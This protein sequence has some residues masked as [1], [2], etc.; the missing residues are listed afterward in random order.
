[1]FDFLLNFSLASCECSADDDDEDDFFSDPPPKKTRQT[2]VAQPSSA[3]KK[4]PPVS[5]PGP[6]LVT[7]DIIHPQ[8]KVYA[9]FIMAILIGDNNATFMFSQVTLQW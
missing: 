6:K 1:L 3:G 9:F 5:K 7:V 8:G 4:L 2:P